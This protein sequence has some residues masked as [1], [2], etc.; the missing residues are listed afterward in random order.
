MHI[1]KEMLINAVGLMF[2]V[3]LIFI[4][5]SVFNRS[6]DAATFFGRQQDDTMQ[7]LEEYPIT[8]Y[9]GYEINGS[10]AINL[11]KEVIGSYDGITVEV[12]TTAVPE[13]FVITDSSKYAAF[14]DL[15]STYYINPIVLYLVTVE[16]DGNGVITSLQ[17]EYVDA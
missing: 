11:I 1:T 12:K 14:R 17:I 7:A 13:G 2:T 3:A 8:K 15:S 5:Y 16:R 10:V 4:G 6:V 9:D